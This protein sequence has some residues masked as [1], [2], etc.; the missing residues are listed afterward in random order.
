MKFVAVIGKSL[1]GERIAVVAEHYHVEGA[2]AEARRRG[3][4]VVDVVD[5]VEHWSVVIGRSPEMG[6][7]GQGF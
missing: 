6:L 5:V 7:K 3:C 2:K 1:T 4:D